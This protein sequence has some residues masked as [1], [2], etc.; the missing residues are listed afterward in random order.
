MANLRCLVTSLRHFC[1][2]SQQVG[3]GFCNLSK[4]E[5]VLDLK[6]TIPRWGNIDFNLRRLV[7]LLSFRGLK[8]NCKHLAFQLKR[9]SKDYDMQVGVSFC[10]L[11]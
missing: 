10:N 4:I 2:Y 3:L 9:L 8:L 6:R 11:R 5:V 7:S 1:L